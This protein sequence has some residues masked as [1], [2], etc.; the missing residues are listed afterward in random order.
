MLTN[1]FKIWRKLSVRRLFCNIS[2]E[3]LLEIKGVLHYNT[4]SYILKILRVDLL[5]KNHDNPLAGYCGVEK[6]LELFSRRYYWFK[7]R[8]DMKKFLTDCNI[9]KS[10][11]AQRHKL[12]DNMQ[13]LSVPIHIWKDLGIDFKTRL[14]KNKDWPGVEY[15]ITI[16]IVDWLTKMVYYES[17]FTTLTGEKLAEVLIEAVIGYDSLLHSI[18]T[19]HESQFTSKFC[20]LLCYHLNVNS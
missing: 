17:V 13:T 8:A 6:I 10:S 16:V 20:L 7:M 11:K 14:L 3:L 5:E 12:Y 4:K 15:K 2:G 18:V 9:C 19:D 1:L